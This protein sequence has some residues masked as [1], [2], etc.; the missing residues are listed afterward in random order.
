MHLTVRL[1]PRVCDLAQEDK[2][3]YYYN[4]MSHLVHEYESIL[5]RLQPT[6]KPLLRPHLEDME[7]K[8]APGFSL[9][10]WT[11]MNIDGYMH[12]FKQVRTHAW[13]HMLGRWLVSRS[14]AWLRLLRAA[15]RL[16]AARV[17]ESRKCKALG[18][19]T[20]HRG[21]PLS[22]PGHAVT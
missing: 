1:C 22:V 16:H 21:L 19:C 3:K 7:A 4:Q 12:R 18:R 8:I 6:I 10:T 20:M 9:L 17:Y 5:G 11:S 14:G 2:Y 13:L 15:S